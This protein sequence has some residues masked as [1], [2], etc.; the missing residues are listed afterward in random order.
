M[1]AGSRCCCCSGG[2]GGGGGLA[3]LVLIVAGAAAGYTALTVLGFLVSLLNTLLI[4]LAVVVGVVALGRIAWVVVD[5]L[6]FEAECR[7]A[8]APQRAIAATP[9]RLAI[10]ATPPHQIAPVH[11]PVLEPVVLNQKEIR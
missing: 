6:A 7:R 5:H 10:T 9:T 1:C 2:G 4:A 8:H 3:A 11:R